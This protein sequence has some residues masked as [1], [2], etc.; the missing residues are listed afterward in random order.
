MII[1]FTE[2]C[3]FFFFYSFAEHKPHI[4]G[5]IETIVGEVIDGKVVSSSV[6]NQ[7][8]EIQ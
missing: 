7:V 3:F 4:E 8:L 2:L 6:D 1:R 5:I